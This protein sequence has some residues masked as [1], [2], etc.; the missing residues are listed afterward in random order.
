MPL[1]KW[2]KTVLKVEFL[3]IT[4]TDE[5]IF[6]P[7]NH[8][9]IFY[10]SEPKYSYKVKTTHASRAMA[11]IQT[12]TLLSSWAFSS[13]RASSVPVVSICQ[14]W[15]APHWPH[16]TKQNP[17]VSAMWQ[18]H[19]DCFWIMTQHVISLADCQAP[20]LVWVWWYE[21]KMT[22]FVESFCWEQKIASL[23]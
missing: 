19:S 9:P 15:T 1:N 6:A 2:C 20:D 8:P 18:F 13:G 14:A 7:P 23:C 21:L 11:S 16:L 5:R 4:F 10:S 17:V 22:Y 12:L 3:N